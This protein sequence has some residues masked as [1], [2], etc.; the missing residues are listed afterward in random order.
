MLVFTSWLF[1]LPILP[2]PLRCLSPF[3]VNANFSPFNKQSSGLPLMILATVNLLL[4]L[5]A[6]VIF[7]SR[8]LNI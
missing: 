8:D 4:Y 2:P 5:A 6:Q 7:E 1:L 3:T